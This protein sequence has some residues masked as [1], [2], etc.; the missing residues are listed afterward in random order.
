MKIT[1]QTMAKTY[2][3]S[4][5][6]SSIHL[7]G[8]PVKDRIHLILA[9]NYGFRVS[10][11]GKPPQ[12]LTLRVA[13]GHA[14]AQNEW[15]MAE[16]TFTAAFQ[17]RKNAQWVNISDDAAALR[18]EIWGTYQA[19][20]KEYGG[21]PSPDQMIARMKVNTEQIEHIP[22]AD[23]I[24][25]II[26]DPTFC[27][28][29]RTR[30]KYMT[31]AALF[32]LLPAVRTLAKD[33]THPLFGWIKG[34]GEVMLG[35]FTAVDWN[36]FSNLI[37]R[38][39]AYLPYSTSKNKKTITSLKWTTGEQPSRY[40]VNTLEKYQQQVKTALKLVSIIFSISSSPNADAGVLDATPALLMRQ[41]SR[42]CLSLM[43][44]IISAMRGWSE[45]SASLRITFFSAAHSLFARFLPVP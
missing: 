37:A 33:E 19:L 4:Y 42:P 39:A 30:K 27:N 40:S 31:T 35:L 32:D 43:S 41:S 9:F 14:L 5:S 7:V 45:T 44:C 15:D 28:N 23:Y 8:R 12:Y 1:S 6:P 18:T 16:Q 36:D 22:L 13:T 34:E 11:R 29:A 25:Q 10:E 2:M 24:R 38:A 17:K 3:K 20:S 26:V 21:K